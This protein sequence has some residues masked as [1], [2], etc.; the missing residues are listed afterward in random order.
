MA[1]YCSKCNKKF[2]FF[3]ED[4]DSMCRNC[5]EKKLRQDEIERQERIKKQEEERKK[6]EH[7]R[8]IQEEKEREEKRRQEEKRREEEK[9]KQEEKKRVEEERKL[10][11]KKKQEIKYRKFK[12][13]YF[14]NAEALKLY[15]D[16]IENIKHRPIITLY[17]DDSEKNWIVDEFEIIIKNIIYMLPQD[18]K[19]N[20]LKDVNNMQ[21]FYEVI[22]KN[23]QNFGID[24]LLTDKEYGDMYTEAFNEIKEQEKEKEI[25]CKNEYKIYLSGDK[26]DLDSDISD[27]YY[28]MNKD[29]SDLYALRGELATRKF[30]YYCAL[31]YIYNIVT[32]QYKSI[33][34]KSELGTIFSNLTKNTDDM[35]Y[36]LEK[37]YDIYIKLYKNLFDIELSKADMNRICI[38]CI[39]DFKKYIKDIFMI[40]NQ[41]LKELVGDDNNKGK[42]ELICK[43]IFN[44]EFTI[45]NL[46]YILNN[47][48]VD[49]Q[50]IAL[51]ILCFMFEELSSLGHIEDLL[52]KDIIFYQENI[53]DT[54]NELIEEKEL[55]EAQKERDRLLNGDFSKEIEMEKQAVEYSNVQNGYEFE[56]YV[57]N[58][59]RKLGYT[60]EEVT[61]KSGDQ[62]CRCCGI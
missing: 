41:S 17:S 56:E 13:E 55:V 12:S 39:G 50:L 35:N 58:L 52:F 3:E 46:E 19:L 24:I 21:C 20:D 5:Y 4:F 27:K 59:Y 49:M 9:K 61:K 1:R 54:I 32:Y 51:N 40:D 16:I 62:R 7:E 18:F 8:R 11:E 22:E 44:N 31:I 36:V 37:I 47:S 23:K 57:A 48:N 10:K 42:F 60:I 15:L 26:I 30:I 25:V 28:E 6:I 43:Y 45:K 33:F 14:T 38:L 34:E 29:I 2:G 53:I